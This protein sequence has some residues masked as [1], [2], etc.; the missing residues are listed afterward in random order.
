MDERPA[1]QKLK[2]YV[3]LEWSLVY[4]EEDSILLLIFAKT[5]GKGKLKLGKT[6]TYGKIR[7]LEYEDS[8]S[9]IVSVL[10]VESLGGNQRVQVDDDNLMDDCCHPKNLRKDL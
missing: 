8:D 7:N 4:V 5:E 9:N 2:N 3:D 6:F 1:E 10:D